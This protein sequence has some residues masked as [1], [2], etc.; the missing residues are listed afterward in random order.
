MFRGSK[1]NKQAQ[2]TSDLK[3]K[4]LHVPLKDRTPIEPP[5]VIVAVVGPPKVSIQTLVFGFGEFTMSHTFLFIHHT[6]RAKRRSSRV[7]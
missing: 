2:R 5:P 4:K 1:A 6:R 3:E 7:L